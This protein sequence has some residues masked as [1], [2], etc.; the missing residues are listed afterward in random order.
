[1][2]Y[3]VL[4]MAMMF[5]WSAAGVAEEA[6]VPQAA[7]DNLGLGG[8]QVV[9]DDEGLQVRGMSVYRYGGVAHR[10]R[11]IGVTVRASAGGSAFRGRRVGAFGG[12]GYSLLR[13]GAFS[14]HRFA[15]AAAVS[16][17]V[18]AF[19]RTRHGVAIGYPGLLRY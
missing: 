16:L 12:R 1:M 3:F 19:S 4:A 10:S 17:D 11:V 13:V 7:L 15:T 2:R 5:L 8:M 14:N 18:A 6:D 9:S